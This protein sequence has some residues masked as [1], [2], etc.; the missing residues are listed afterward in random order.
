MSKSTCHSSKNSNEI[1]PI[2]LWKEVY[3]LLQ[4]VGSFRISLYSVQSN[5][6]LNVVKILMKSHIFCQLILVNWDLMRPTTLNL[7]SKRLQGPCQRLA[8]PGIF[9][10]FVF[11]AFAKRAQPQKSPPMTGFSKPLA[12][13]LEPLGP[14]IQCG[15]SHQVPNDQN[16]LTNRT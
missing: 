7:G 12:R 5:P 16:Q 1:T 13:P 6:L 4:Y 11:A 9:V 15:W 3:T 8:N 2:M 10:T 14:Q